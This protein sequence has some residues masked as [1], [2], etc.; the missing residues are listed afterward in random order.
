MKSLSVGSI[1]FLFFLQIQ[2]G[3]AQNVGI[4]VSGLSPNTAAIL[5][6]DA[7]PNFNKGLL[8]P[9]VT[10][11]QRTTGFNPLSAAAQGLTVYQTDA[12][13]F[14]EGFYFNTSTSTTPAWSFLLNNTS[15]W[16]LTGNAVTT[17]ST[18]AIGTA[19]NNNFIGTTDAKDFVMATNNLERLRISSAGN[20]G[21]GTLSPTSSA[22]LTIN[23]T[24]NAIRN[25]IDMT[26]PGS[27]TISS[28]A[29]GVNIAV[30]S[31]AN[32]RGFLY[33]NS[34]TGAGVF[35]GVGTALTG[36]ITAEG[37]LSY[38][39]SAPNTYAVYG[40]GG[41]WAGYFENGKVAITSA[42]P[43]TGTSD[44]EI[45][46][47]TS[48]A[49]P[50]TFSMRT[51][52][53]VTTAA[54][55]IA[56]LNFSDS[57]NPST[58]GQAQIQIIRDAASTGGV[59]SSDYP[60]A[61]AFSTT[62]DASAT[63]T[64]RMRITNNGNVGI[65]TTSP[66]AKLEISQLA[67][68]AGGNGLTITGTGT[69]AQNW[70]WYPSSNQSLNLMRPGLRLALFG[71]DGSFAAGGLSND[72][73]ADADFFV[74]GTSGNV[75]IG[76]TSPQRT[77][78]INGGDG[79]EQIIR[80]T[81]VASG[82][83]SWGIQAFLGNLNFRTLDDGITAET[84]VGKVLTLTRT[85]NVG[86]GTTSP[87][88]QLHTTGSVRFQTLTGTG[89]RFVITDLNGNIS[90]GAATTAG[91]VTGSGTLNYVPKWTPNGA[92]LGNSL[93]FDNGT[94]V[95][96]G[97]TSPGALLQIGE[98][99]NHY[100]RFE[101]NVGLSDYYNA[102]TTPR[103][104][105]AID[106][107]GSGLS[108]YTL[109]PPGTTIAAGGVALGIAASQNLG[110]YTSNGSALTERLRI[111]GS[112]NVG[113]G[114]SAPGAK[115][116]IRGNDFY[117]GPYANTPAAFVIY[118]AEDLNRTGGA[119]NTDA[120]ASNGNNWGTNAN[121]QL[122]GPYRSLP[123]GNY[124]F[125]A[126]VKVADASYTGN[127][128]RMTVIGTG[129]S[130]RD[131]YIRGVDM[132]ANNE[133]NML[134]VPFR[135]TAVTGNTV[136]VYV[137]GVNSQQIYTDYI[138]IVPDVDSQTEQV[139]GNFYTSGNIG[140]GTNSPGAKLEI[141]G[142][143]K[144]TGGAPGAGK[145]L[146]SDAAGLATW[147]TPSSGSVAGS[148]TLNYVPKWTP[149]GTTLGNSSIF[150]NGNVGIGSI[151]PGQRLTVDAPYGLAAPSGATQNGILRLQTDN[152][153]GWGEVFD[154]G[155][156]VGVSGPA[157]HAWLQAT[158]KG[159]LAVNYNLVLNPNGGNVG[160]GTTS[161]V[162]KFHLSNGAPSGLGGLPANTL[163][164]FDNGSANNYLTFRNTADNGTYSGIQFQDNN[165]GGYIAFRNYVGSGAN[166]GN[167]GDYM[168]YGSYTDHI[169][170]NGASEAVNGKTETMRI[171]QN[172]NVGIGTAAPGGKLHIAQSGGGA[173]TRGSD[174]VIERLGASNTTGKISFIGNGGIGSTRWEVV[175]DADV[176][177]DFGFSYNGTK[178]LQLLT[179]GNVGIG[180]TSPSG[181]LDVNGDFYIKGVTGINNHYGSYSLGAGIRELFRVSQSALCTGGTFTIFATRNSFVHTTQWA[182][183]STHNGSGRGVLTQLS[184][185]EYSNI[186]VYLDV[187]SDGSIIIS[188]DWGAAQGYNISIQKTSGAVLDLNNAGTDWSTVNAGYTR[189]RTVNTISNGFQT[190]NA[191]FSGNVG[192][193]TTT[194]STQLH[195]TGGVRFQNLTGTGNRFVITDLNGN[196]S[197]GA[198][199]TAGIIAGS[200]TLNYVPKW[201]PDG[202]TLG[203]SSIFD[204]GNVG[205]GTTN[206]YSK[207]S[208]TSDNET[209][210]FSL[211]ASGYEPGRLWGTRIFKKDCY[212]GIGNATA[213]NGIPLTIETQ[214]NGTWYSSA[215]FGAG[216]DIN[217]PTLR[218]FGQTYLASNGGNVGIGTTAP[219]AKLVV[220]QAS[221]SHEVAHFVQG[222][223]TSYNVDV[224]LKGGTTA[225]W[226]LSKRTVDG[227]GDFWFYNPT[228]GY[229][230]LTLKQNGNVGI[231][232]TGPTSK[233]HV[234][235][236][237]RFT[238][239][240]GVDAG[241]DIYFGREESFGGSDIGGS[242][243]GYIHFDND[244][245][246]YNYWGDG[247]E[248]SAFIIGSQN[249]PANVNSDVLVV[250]G[251]AANIFDSPNHLFVSGNVGIGT[252]APATSLDVNGVINSA[253]GYRIANAAASGN[254]LRG[255]GTNFV[256][257]ALQ[258]GDLPSHTHPWS[259]V[260][261]K[262]AAWLNDANL[263]QDLPNF[264]NS[265]PSGFYQ[266]YNSTNAPRDSWVN[267]INV[268]HS[269]PGNDHGFQIAAS[270]YDQNIWSRTYQGGTGANNG[271]YT[272][273]VKLNEST[274]VFSYT[275]GNQNFTVPQGITS[276]KVEVW[277]AKG[278]GGTPGGWNHGAA[279]GDGGYTRGL[280]PV[281]PGESLIIKV[282]EMGYVN[283]GAGYGYGGG[284]S[285][286]NNNVDNR[287]GS[288][289]GGMS[290][291]FRGG[292]P[293]LIAGGGGGG[294]SSRAW[295][296]NIGG[297]GGGLSGA[298]GL[299][300][301]TICY[302]GSGGT[303][304][305]VGAGT[306]GGQSG[307]QYQGG[308]SGTNSY[309]GGGGGGWWGGSGGGYNE[310]NT[311]GGGGGGSGYIHSTIVGG[312]SQTGASGG[313]GGISSQG[314]HGTVIITY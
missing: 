49:I 148:G 236:S 158:N 124:K 248:N 92:T 234:A 123:I 306:C 40:K 57:R 101:T 85:G 223:P 72:G 15:G 177:N 69:G 150:D 185:G 187:A 91:I 79:V 125:V 213:C 263:I 199:T 171:K 154:L 65:G 221:N 14:G 27:G 32:I 255:N 217:H 50:A 126:R 312:V 53:E 77:F 23:P 251:A 115:L 282:G 272:T 186:T 68:D 208:L 311:M 159:N 44:L 56:S 52:T 164:S 5:D 307:T 121:F 84:G 2:F 253:T 151:S 169:F 67:S 252:T 43:P 137:L 240:L 239:S 119:T 133:W 302:G 75:G 120:T 231:G 225:D 308:H 153:V 304:T 283:Q 293:L 210:G 277:G 230:V 17:A 191:A 215:M 196:I 228:L 183:S 204:N 134:S 254:Y 129:V 110:L 172:G 74:N 24:T 3:F 261:S 7:A 35:Y 139:W 96:I 54:N 207:L 205:I 211:F 201:T 194:P 200:G 71:N 33:S 175:S 30:T 238:G 90:A 130:S 64:E 1:L 106:Q 305:G 167:N 206:P 237:S 10:F 214:Y 166:D 163:A 38:R 162:S 36:G 269:N 82:S 309:G 313:G 314:A 63:L 195:S 70:Q 41:S 220:N 243:Y 295:N 265:V 135:V 93:I 55:N 198:A 62:P 105:I 178:M 226:L 37:Y 46:N 81:G 296:D 294:G 131:R 268:R 112:G 165:V 87:S 31:N 241:N 300:P 89:N 310:P 146:T 136:E 285:G 259:A 6:I 212:Q 298:F 216:Q 103:W 181:K 278:A 161:P 287:Y 16:S 58:S 114:T 227:S 301:Y 233:F 144:I 173:Y 86:I 12:G 299:S 262:P 222:V 168:V 244:N 260:T 188:A 258:V 66:S 45:Q 80:N 249:D 142:Q 48:G 29:Y 128:F 180:T 18:S 116:E 197:A 288:G 184:S 19:A 28:I 292:T 94:N 250:K 109:A 284:A 224:W 21:I 286:T 51:T 76:T 160:I 209:G 257:S 192:I 138:M 245:N 281:T 147:N 155:M 152:G 97:T 122:Y 246:S 34:T 118:E 232:T 104:R 267:L 4:N 203:N 303:Q 13:G 99:P 229:S 60:T 218:T 78:Q 157:S 291:I 83:Q 9:R 176:G 20:I 47:T 140:I 108:A 290:A 279:G 174:L 73:G 156:H 297:G 170:Q 270:Y 25:A 61:I 266:G 219:V 95:G 141:A 264:N 39:S 149:N 280:V 145:V 271:S 113:I 274:V 98:A 42:N 127:S 179:N 88:T 273:W 193:G 11:S 202:N 189:V 26:F 247:G 235:G 256:S 182:W 22:L 190:V 117:L 289:G 143:I 132:T 100:F 102:E 111:N 8:I 275:G 242:D 59:S 276:I 107:I